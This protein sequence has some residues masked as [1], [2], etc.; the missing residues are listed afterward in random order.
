MLRSLDAH[1]LIRATHHLY[2]PE[3]EWSYPLFRKLQRHADMTIPSDCAEVIQAG[4]DPGQVI[5]VKN[6]FWTHQSKF[7]GFI[8][9][10]NPLAIF[11]SWSHMAASS[12]AL[13]P[14]E[15]LNRWAIGI[16]PN[17][18]PGLIGQEKIYSFCA[19][20]NVHMHRMVASGL[21]IVHYERF[22]A[23][24]ETTLRKLCRHFEIEWNN[25]M[26]RT[27]ELHAPGST[28]HGGIKMSEPI[29]P[30][31]TGKYLDL[32]PREIS[33]VFGLCY[34]V[35]DALGYYFS[36]DSTV[37]IRADFNDRF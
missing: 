25:Q 12:N 37:E 10:R 7:K 2:N 20:Y 34:P 1:P 3:P 26:L 33:H 32:P 27:H 31:S 8:L 13:F 4:I 23:D 15:Q 36:E 22:V 17:L 5:V 11:R 14:F 28:G 30:D 35:L 29:H 19:L 6:A 24:P 9:A 18:L 21:P 16:E